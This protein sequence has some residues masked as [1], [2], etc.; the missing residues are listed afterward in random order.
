MSAFHPVADENPLGQMNGMGAKKGR[1]TAG[2]LLARL[3]ADPAYQAM[4]AA[5]DKARA[6]LA[7]RREREQKPLLDDL[8]AIGVTVDWVGGL[9]QIPAPDERIYPI[10]LDHLRRPYNPWLLEWIGRAFGIKPARS[11]V[12]D[13]LI[14]LLKC[15]ALDERAADGVMDAISE[16]AQPRDLP[17]L[18]N[19][20]ADRSLGERRIYLVRNL[21]RYKR[22]EARDTLL[23]LQDDPDLTTEITARLARSRT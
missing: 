12:W 22:P 23:R 1:M 19:L 18:I 11:V 15:H 9:V 8:A 10:L 13:V 3:D 6:E 2:E 17:T 16:I 5:K 4:R 14:S 21:M 20:I 7:E